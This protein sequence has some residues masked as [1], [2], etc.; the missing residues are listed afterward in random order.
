MILDEL[1]SLIRDVNPEL[2]VFYD[3]LFIASR[4]RLEAIIAGLEE[5]GL[6]GKTSFM[7]H[8]RANLITDDICVLLKRLGMVAVSLGVESFSDEVLSYYNKTSVTGEVNQRALDLLHKHGI[9]ALT[10]FMFG[11]PFETKEDI[12]LTLGGIN[13]NVVNGKIEEGQWAILKP[14]P[15]TSVWDWA[16]QAGIVS[17]D[18]DW[19]KFK[20]SRGEELYLGKEVGW[21]AL[22]EIIERWRV[23]YT[24][25]RPG[26][27]PNISTNSLF[28]NS[29]HELRTGIQGV[30]GCGVT[31]GECTPG[32]DV[33]WKSFGRYLAERL[34]AISNGEDMEEVRILLSELTSIYSDDPE[35]MVI[36]GRVLAGLGEYQDARREFIKATVLAPGYVPGYA[37]LIKT[38]VTMGRKAEAA[39]YL[40]I[41]FSFA[42][43]GPE[44]VNLH[45]RLAQSMPGVS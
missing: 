11:A 43:N 14:F 39:H 30:T 4:S 16:E 17:S 34:E 22:V 19:E 45:N 25:L 20:E 15:G 23:K 26:R 27:Q 38:L 31:N 29:I 40:Q 1:E 41:A 2:I 44:F 8:V 9:S 3:D 37:N 5:R 10:L 24:L 42:P 33:T 18:M 28:F 6:S 21:T 7:G 13:R 35:M 12:D 32:V 36:S